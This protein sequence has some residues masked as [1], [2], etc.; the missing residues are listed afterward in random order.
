MAVAT[1]LMGLCG[2]H[3]AS[4]P[5]DTSPSSEV[6]LKRLS[7]VEQLQVAEIS[8]RKT[9]SIDDLKP[10]EVEGAR[11]MVAAMIDALKIGDRKAVYSY[12]T[13]LRAYVDLGELTPAD[14]TVD[15]AARHISITLPD[16]HTDYAGRD[17]EF[18]EEH[19]RVTGLRS[20]IDSEERARL[21]ESMNKLL[22]EEVRQNDEFS[23]LLIETGR[24]RAESFVRTF[25]GVD[26][27][28]VE[29]KWKNR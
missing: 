24:R 21:K 11:Q 18:R 16:L 23:R 2:C 26:G 4:A 3:R 14:I 10:S 19:Y 8:I 6:L 5:A 25:L 12:D 17:A 1:A 15:T 7:G 28:Q 20:A 29:V 13:Y 9:A 27:Y 22:K